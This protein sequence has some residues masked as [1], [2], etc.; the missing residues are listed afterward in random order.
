MSASYSTDNSFFHV[1]RWL[2]D[3]TMQ[4]LKS[5]NASKLREQYFMQLQI[6]AFTIKSD[7]LAAI[8]NDSWS[9]GL[10]SVVSDINIF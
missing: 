2:L 9:T 3:L 7:Y 1:A 10:D 4:P 5:V 6:L 8:E